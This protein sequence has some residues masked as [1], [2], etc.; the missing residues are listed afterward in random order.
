MEAAWAVIGGKAAM[1]I[2]KSLTLDDLRFL[3][4]E[5]PRKITQIA[6]NKR[7]TGTL[8]ARKTPACQGIAI[9]FAGRTDK[10]HILI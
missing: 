4:V 10:T 5:N 1:Q 8:F 9:Q 2:A 3:V 6:V 7:Q